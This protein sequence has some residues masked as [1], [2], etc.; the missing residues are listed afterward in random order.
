MAE[1]QKAVWF[2]SG[3]IQRYENLKIGTDFNDKVR[4]LMY[5]FLD[6]AE[7]EKLGRQE[8]LSHSVIEQIT[9]EVAMRLSK[10]AAAAKVQI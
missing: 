1:G 5:D 2:N 10:Q 8:F 4:S 7:S 3:D 9:Q 6:K